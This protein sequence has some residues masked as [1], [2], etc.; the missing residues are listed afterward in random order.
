MADPEDRRRGARHHVYLAAE[1]GFDGAP[2]S[3]AITKDVSAQGLLVLTRVRLEP[4]QP[5]RLR[6]YLPGD[7]DRV[8]VVSGR[9]VRRETLAPDERGTW[10]EKVALAFDEPQDSLADEF[11]ALAAEQA[12]IY[13]W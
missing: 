13:G 10:R 3:T 8:A 12:R 2:G 4:E 5:I 11:A 9:V 6:V 7:E 1:L